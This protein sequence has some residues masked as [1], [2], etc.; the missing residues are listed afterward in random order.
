M[1]A[2]KPKFPACNEGELVAG[3][4]PIMRNYYS[5]RYLLLMMVPGLLY[6][7]LFKYAPMYGIIIAFKDLNIMQGIFA[8]PWVGFKHFEALFRSPDFVRVFRNTL[9]IST[10]K[11]VFT[12]PAPIVLA[13]LLNEVRITLFKRVIQTITYLPHFLSWVIL[14]GIVINLL[15]PSTGLVNV[16]LNSIGVK[17]IFFVGDPDWFRTVLVVSG[18]WKEVGWG[19]IIYMAA[20]A[21]VDS[22]LYEAMAI[23][24]RTY[25]PLTCTGWVWRT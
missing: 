5:N 15:S 24:C 10:Y 14:S 1:P 22:Q 12:F 2:T 20:L 3:R 17:T 23:R 16:I 25:S 11:L 9:I 7:V 19:T 6:Y 4:R 13:I 21:S 18:A 8:S